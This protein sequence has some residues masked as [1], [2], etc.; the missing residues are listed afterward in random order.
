MLYYCLK[1]RRKWEKYKPEGG[2][3]KGKPMPL[4]KCVVVK[5]KDLS[6]GK[7]LVE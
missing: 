6:N 3:D 7:K 5:N 4:S 2:K 1:S